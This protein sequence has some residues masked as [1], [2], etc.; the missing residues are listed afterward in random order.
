M[1]RRIAAALGLAALAPV[2]IYVIFVGS[3]GYKNWRA[4]VDGPIKSRA[5]LE[6]LKALAAPLGYTEEGRL[7][8]SAIFV[9]YPEYRAYADL[10][11]KTP[12]PL[13]RFTEAAASAFPDLPP[14][15]TYD[16]HEIRRPS[17]TEPNTYLWYFGDVAKPTPT[18]D[19]SFA[20]KPVGAVVNLRYRTL[21]E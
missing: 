16:T 15:S 4:R 1:N 13:E 5:A 17:K 6:R 10:A 9:G 12:L 8:E 14:Q 18:L 2:A 3:V 7:S 21:P 11:F 20:A 19:V